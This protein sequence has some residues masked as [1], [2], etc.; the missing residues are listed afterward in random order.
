MFVASAACGSDVFAPAS[1]VASGAAFGFAF[2]LGHLGDTDRRWFG[3]RFGAMYEVKGFNGRVSFDGEVVVVKRKGAGE[4]RIPVR[5]IRSVEYK[6]GGLTQGY[7]RFDTG[8]GALQTSVMKNKSRAL[9][10]DPSTVVFQKWRNKDFEELANAITNA[11][12][13]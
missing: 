10:E 7:I 3:D 4:Q 1:C 12:Y 6:K 13:Q 8:G 9:L 2:W 5:A 11:I